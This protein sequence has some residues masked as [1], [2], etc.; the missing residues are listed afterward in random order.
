VGAGKS[1][2][3]PLRSALTTLM[4]KRTS[5]PATAGAGDT[6]QAAG[7]AMFWRW[8]TPNR[9]ARGRPPKDV[10]SY[11]AALNLFFD[12]RRRDLPIASGTGSKFVAVL[13]AQAG[14]KP[15]KARTVVRT[16][17]KAWP[18]IPKA[19]YEGEEGD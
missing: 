2:Q 15:A 14:I 7:E 13:A 11:A 4:K 12:F 17:L 19:V 16:L 6:Y 1:W 10:A 18:F 9:P 8:G 5:S 3:K